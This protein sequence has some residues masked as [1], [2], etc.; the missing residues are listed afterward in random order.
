AAEQF[1]L[2]KSEDN[3][4]VCIN[5]YR[6]A[7]GT[8]ITDNCPRGLR[9]LRD[10]AVRFKE[11]VA[12]LFILLLATLGQKVGADDKCIKTRAD[13]MRGN[14]VMMTPET[15]KSNYKAGLERALNSLKLEGNDEN[16]D[17]ELELAYSI[18]ES[19]I[20]FSKSLKAADCESIALSAEA[21]CRFF[22]GKYSDA[23]E[24]NKKALISANKNCAGV[25]KANLARAEEALKQKRSSRPDR[26]PARASQDIRWLK[27]PEGNT[28][29]SAFN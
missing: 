25:I 19:V 9:K 5:F 15:L 1:L 2:Q 6:R 23:V 17:K 20:G 22:M 29:T 14:F 18:F 11:K 4:R 10:S 12:A 21:N 13:S 24:L 27:N 7:D 28:V 26:G 3:S 16:T 8:I